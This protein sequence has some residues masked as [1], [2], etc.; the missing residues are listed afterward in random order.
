MAGTTLIVEETQILAQ[1]AEE[2]TLLE[3]IEV[4]E[5]IEVAHQG[6]PG[7]SLGRP[8]H[9]I[10]TSPLPIAAGRCMLPSAPLGAVIWNMALVYLDLTPDDFDAAGVLLTDRDYLVEDHLVQTA[11]AS[12]LFTHPAPADGLYAVVSYIT[13]AP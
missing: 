5:I 13:A 2:S 8:I 9:L 6:P 4:I 1:Q 7:S 10:T 3:Q 11:G 12:V